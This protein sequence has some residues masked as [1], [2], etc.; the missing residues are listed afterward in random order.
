MFWVFLSN[1]GKSSTCICTCITY[2]FRLKCL[3]G[4]KPWLDLRIYNSLLERCRTVLSSKYYY[5]T[6]YELIYWKDAK[7]QHAT[8]N[9]VSMHFRDGYLCVFIFPN[10]IPLPCNNSMNQCQHFPQTKFGLP[11]LIG[12]LRCF[13]M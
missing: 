11:R 3:V 2:R 10:A 6:C 5:E 13:D 7:I 8:R 1:G 9:K 12:P 4:A